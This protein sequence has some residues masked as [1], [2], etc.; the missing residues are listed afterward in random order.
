MPAM[1]QVTIHGP[2]EVFE[3]GLIAQDICPVDYANDIYVPTYC[4]FR[5]TDRSVT[6]APAG[7]K[8]LFRINITAQATG[9]YNVFLVDDP[10]SIRTLFAGDRRFSTTVKGIE[11]VGGS[12]VETLTAGDR[13]EMTIEMV[14]VPNHRKGPTERAPLYI[15]VTG[16][17]VTVPTY[18]F[19]FI[20]DE[21]VGYIG[22]RKAHPYGPASL[23]PTTPTCYHRA[24]C[25][26]R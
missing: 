10:S 25:A 3:G 13:R 1:A 15:R 21:Y 5:D 11:V 23:W 24:G 12:A 20:D 4:E 16:P 22:R 2:K 19:D 9:Q 17:N 8:A 7:R 14:G 26:L 18:E 6:R